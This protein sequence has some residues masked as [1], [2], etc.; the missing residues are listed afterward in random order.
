MTHPNIEAGENY[1]EH[2]GVLGMHWGVYKDRQLDRKDKKWLDKSNKHSTYMKLYNEGARRMNSGLKAFNA[3]PEFDKVDTNP[4]NPVNK[5]YYDAYAKYATDILND[6][7]QKYGGSPSGELRL[8]FD[9]DPVNEAMPRW[10]IEDKTVRHSGY[11][12]DIKVNITIDNSG[13][14][15][16]ATF[17]ISGELA[18]YGVLGMQWGKH[19]PGRGENG[20]PRRQPVPKSEDHIKARILNSKPKSALTNSELKVLNERLQLEQTNSKLKGNSSQLAKIKKG[21]DTI[22]T[23]IGVGTTLGVVY[24]LTQKTSIGKKIVSNLIDQYGK[25]VLDVTLKGAKLALK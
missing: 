4:K 18:H 20:V 23:L 6:V 19:L 17:D 7:A 9:Y 12:D 5:K 2:Y 22:K 1:L 14:I 11:A 25:T 10:R 3:N 21:N 15:T 8:T 16:D 13:K 24:G